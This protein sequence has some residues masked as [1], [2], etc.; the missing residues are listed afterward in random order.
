MARAAAV[1]GAGVAGLASAVVLRRE[2]WDVEVFDERPQSRANTG[3]GL[4]V[5]PNAQFRLTAL[6]IEE[7]AVPAMGLALLDHHSAEIATASADD[8]LARLGGWPRVVLRDQ[9]MKDLEDAAL[10]AGADLAYEQRLTGL[11]REGDRWLLRLGEKQ[12]PVRA[13]V[14]LGCDGI[15]SAVRRFL[16]PGRSA[17]SRFRSRTAY[18]GLS[19][20]QA[21]RAA[22]TEAWGPEGRFGYAPLADG[23]TYWFADVP[24]RPARRA[25]QPGRAPHKV[26][27]VVVPNPADPRRR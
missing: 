5:W 25:P 12:S 24:T 3:S 11:S 18:R 8:L 19:D 15:R 13:D 26:R 23:R 16:A 1:V 2:G 7:V 9:L 17:R 14:V 20:A 27:V 10:G 22:V 6:G 21:P 4:I